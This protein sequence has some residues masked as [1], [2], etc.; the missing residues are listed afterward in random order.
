MYGE[1]MESQK[2]FGKIGTLAFLV[3]ITA[4]PPLTTDIYLPAL[5]QMVEIFGT[6][7]ARVNLTLSCFFIVYSAGLLFWGPLSEKFGR[8]PILLIGHGIYI[9]ASVL[10]ALSQNVD[11]LIIARVLQAFGGSAVTVIATAIVK[12]LY[13][14]RERERVMATVMSM[15]VIAP[16]VAPLLGGVI[17]RFAS[18]QVMFYTLVGFGI[19]SITVSLFYQETLK[20]RY[21][22]S[23]VHSWGR[24]FT[25]L[26]N[27]RF[28]SL[29]LIFSIVSVAFMAYIA[30]ASFV[31]INT[32]GLGEQTFSYFYSFNVLF[33]IVGPQMYIRLSRRYSAPTIISVCFL[34]LM[35]SGVALVTFGR[36]SPWFF[37]A[38]IAP[39]SL[40][41]VTVR[42]PGMNL[43]LEQQ[44]RDTGSAAALITFFGMFMGTGGMFLVSLRPEHMIEALGTIQF[45]IGLICGILWFLVRNRS[46]V[47][48]KIAG[49][50]P[51][52]AEQS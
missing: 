4:F 34:I 46:F 20:E 52:K 18:W 6:T 16:M 27:P 37:A 15:V 17:L 45:V 19:F 41:A 25:V 11:Q 30:A 28:A 44:D 47:Q 14:G 1:K 23:V 21:T 24:L 50:M 3:I 5:P 10:C 13:D 12:D 32:F 43:M 39:A 38:L 51:I 42:V 48:A 26:K 2:Y 22:G 35:I 49:G 9:L 36:I 40:A 7:Y 33:S 8:K 29:L 31:Y